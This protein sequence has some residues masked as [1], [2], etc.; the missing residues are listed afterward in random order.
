MSCTFDNKYFRKVLIH[1]VSNK[2]IYFLHKKFCK[3]FLKLNCT[4][5]YRLTL[6]CDKSKR[7]E[8]RK[9]KKEIKTPKTL[10]NPPHS[11][12]TELISKSPRRTPLVHTGFPAGS[13]LLL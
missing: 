5:G 12:S 7:E 8:K 4:F 9:E 13:Q 3:Y 2:S 10:F 11:L 1:I 6:I